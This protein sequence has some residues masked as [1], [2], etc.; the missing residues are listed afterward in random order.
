MRVYP[1]ARN[2]LT[3][4]QGLLVGNAEDS[5]AWTGVTAVLADEPVLARA[6]VRGG[7]PDTINTDA[8]MPAGLNKCVHA[9]VLS[10]GSAFGLDAAGG[11]T[12]W[13]A[14]RGRCFNEWGFCVPVVVGATIF[15]LVNG[16]SK[17]WGYEAPYRDLAMRAAE[18]ASL[19]IALGNVGAGLGATAGTLKGGLG[20]AS[21]FDEETGITI[22]A[23][24]VTNA[25]GS[26]TMPGSPTFWAWYLE[27]QSE[28]GGQ[29]RPLAATGHTF[30]TKSN[31]GM[32]TTIGVL[33]T[34][35]MLD[36]VSLQRL[37]VMAQAGY[38]FAIRPVSTPFDGDSV[39]ALA[40]CKRALGARPDA[41]LRLGSLAADVMA[42]AVMRGVYEGK[43]L[44]NHVSYQTRWGKY[45]SNGSV[46]PNRFA[47]AP[48]S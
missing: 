20:S 6:D 14:A 2:A 18:S 4:V 1:G 12:A 45:L 23:L 13:L 47:N 15:D 16:G 11:L 22:A 40:T 29:P 21:I 26:P 25:V 33:A 44:G 46:Q 41:V 43:D 48:Y 36:T 32:N 27:Q 35:A 42:R 9:I 10:G 38:A 34:D 17:D 19:D 39:F 7:A 30:E 31:I 3:D 28:L 5:A 8:L 37:A 24:V